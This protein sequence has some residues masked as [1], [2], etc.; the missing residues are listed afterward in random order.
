MLCCC[1][2]T[3]PAEK[4]V[5][6]ALELSDD[7]THPLKVRKRHFED[8]WNVR[9]HIRREISDLEGIQSNHPIIS[10]LP[11]IERLDSRGRKVI[12]CRHQLQRTPPTTQE[13]TVAKALR[14]DQPCDKLQA[15]SPS[16][17]NNANVSA[18]DVSAAT[19]LELNCP[20]AETTLEDG[21]ALYLV[22]PRG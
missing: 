18:R 13:S 12:S 21:S 10:I 2:S 22:T 14:P 20:S 5:G 19:S 16:V 11:D 8:Q 9:L 17:E 1:L 6:G 15:K 3:R 7:V 4:Y